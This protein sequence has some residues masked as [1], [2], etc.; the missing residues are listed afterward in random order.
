MKLFKIDFNLISV[1]VLDIMNIMF[2]VLFSLV[3]MKIFDAII[4][5]NLNEFYKNIFLAFI[6]ISIQMLTFYLYS[7]NKNKY[8]KNK[9]N[10]LRVNTMKNILE[11]KYDDYVLKEKAEYIN[12]ILNDLDDIDYKYFNAIFE[13]I[14]K[15]LLLIFS[16]ILIF[17]INKIFFIVLIIIIATITLLPNLFSKI[18]YNMQIKCMNSKLNFTEQLNECL[19]G[20]KTIK[21][22]NMIDKINQFYKLKANNFDENNRKF[23]DL[24]ALINTIFATTTMIIILSIFIVGGNLVLNNKI[25]LSIIIAILQL[26]MN[27]IDSTGAITENISNL[28]GIKPL[29]ERIENIKNINTENDYCKCESLHMIEKIELKRVSYKYLNQEKYAIKNVN[30]TFEKGKKY[31]I[32]GNN[33]SGKSTLLKIIGNI[34]K[35]YKGDIYFNGIN[36]NNFSS[37]DI[38]RKFTYM[39][40]DDFLFND[41]IVNNI[42]IFS[43]KRLNLS[44]DLNNFL[45]SDEI[46]KKFNDENYKV[47]YNGEKLS[48]GEKQKIC[49]LRAIF[50]LNEILILDESDSALDNHSFEI[51]MNTL[52]KNN[53][54]IC[55]TH[56]KVED[57]NNFDY[58]ITMD[59]GEIKSI[60]ENNR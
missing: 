43:N 26:S 59:N 40:Q 50:N 32:I 53:F 36:S 51:I 49:I 37:K 35:N 20:F 2:N 24:L 55:V 31:A 23:K 30:I 42:S 11:L 18:L 60:K 25:E 19:D 46:I 58:I 47:G 54:L 5:K 45:F 56:K 48:G 21:S 27:I 44:Y 1:F 7:K 15:T 12:I 22:Y 29:F 10:Y 28:N 4:K 14:S 33:G 13:L 52:N 34:I 57:L 38:S 17:F 9:I 6:C 16:S 8:I 41:S 39:H 3:S